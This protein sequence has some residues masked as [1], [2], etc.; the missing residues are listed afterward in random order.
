MLNPFF[1]CTEESYIQPLSILHFFAN[2]VAEYLVPVDFGAGN[3]KLP[4]QGFE[5]G[6]WHCLIVFANCCLI[7]IFCMLYDFNKLLGSLGFIRNSYWIL[8]IFMT[9]QLNIAIFIIVNLCEKV[10]KYKCLEHIETYCLEHK[11]MPSATPNLT[12]SE[13]TINMANGNL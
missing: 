6:V 8:Y 12:N 10:K 7:L 2:L 9:N 11:S 3:R 5:C 1:P 13:Q 4:A